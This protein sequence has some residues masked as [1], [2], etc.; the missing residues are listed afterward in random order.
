MENR[1][2]TIIRSQHKADANGFSLVEVSAAMVI[3]GVTLAFAMPIILQSRISSMK[4]QAKTGAMIVAQQVFDEIRGRN[5]ASL[6]TTDQTV[7]PGGP[8]ITLATATH[9]ATPIQLSADKA[10]ALGRKYKVAIRFCA[11]IAP[12]TTTECTDGY[13]NFTITVRDP[14]GDQTKD[15]SILYEVSANLTNFL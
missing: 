10:S 4:D 11:P 5:F 6:P 2:R 12:A 14:K 13:R 15:S 8:A 3:F 7:T 9:M 1:L